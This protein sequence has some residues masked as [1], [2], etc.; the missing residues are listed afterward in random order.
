MRFIRASATIDDALDDGWFGE[1]SE[2]VDEIIE[3]RLVVDAMA[4]ILSPTELYVTG[5]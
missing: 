4:E 2:L 1:F 3:T 5:R